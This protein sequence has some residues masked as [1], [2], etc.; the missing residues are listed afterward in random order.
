MEHVLAVANAMIALECSCR[1]NGVEMVSHGDKILKWSVP[2]R[3]RD[4]I[5]KVGIIPDSVFGL[6]SKS[7]RD[8]IEWFFLEA[9][10]ATMPV[11]RRTLKQT[12]FT[13]KLIA[14]Q[15]TWRR[16]VLAK[17]FRRFRVLTVTTSHE[18]VDH[19]LDAHHEFSQSKGSGLFLFT[20][21]K[22]FHPEIDVLKL[23]LRNGRG[24]A[25]TLSE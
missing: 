17:K 19:L 9:D 21:K 23:A 20:H 7:K 12:S 10:R 16:G 14:Y 1:N 24:D 13:R 5:L 4:T 6:R 2:V 22:E 18:R 8:E 3:Y 15:E 11:K 25:V